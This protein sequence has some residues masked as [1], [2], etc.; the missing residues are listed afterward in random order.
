MASLHW[1][2]SLRDIKNFVSGLRQKTG[3]PNIHPLYIIE[4]LINIRY[5]MGVSQKSYLGNQM[6]ACRWHY[7]AVTW[8]SDQC[9]SSDILVNS[10][11]N[12]LWAGDISLFCRP[13]WQYWWFW[14]QFFLDASHS[15]WIMEPALK[16][17]F[18]PDLLNTNSVLL[19]PSG[20]EADC[21]TLLI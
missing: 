18:L 8:Q 12:L 21:K 6:G 5:L 20:A 1:L 13:P 9:A 3:Y 11:G 7:V 10:A 17:V 14:L 19:I 15:P 4:T 16:D 2:L